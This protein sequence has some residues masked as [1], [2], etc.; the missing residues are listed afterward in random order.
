MAQSQ[1][2]KQGD[3]QKEHGLAIKR[4]HRL[5][6]HDLGLIEVAGSR[7]FSLALTKKGWAW[8]EAELT[9]PK[10]KGSAGLGPV[11][12]ALSVIGQLTKRLGLPLER[13]LVPNGLAPAPPDLEIRAPEWIE[14]D[15]VLARALQDISVFS[16]AL[17]RL[18]EAA[19]GT[20]EKEIRRADLS[21][22]LVF[23]N[24]QLA[25]R[26]RAL[27]LDGAAGSET[28]FDPVFFYSDEDIKPGAPVRIRKP[29]VTR[30]QGKKKIII[31]PGLAEAIHS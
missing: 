26:K 13:A 24:V 11:Y 7:A 31:Q 20:L 30:G 19:K 27:D 10:P 12:A 1:P 17:S 14:V 28:S 16:S 23:Q 25:A 29:P 22:N 18:R 9:A 4:S 8:L 5:K 3:F 2:L 6:L 21:A 15:E